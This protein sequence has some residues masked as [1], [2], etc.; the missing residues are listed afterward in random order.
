MKSII[1]IFV[2]IFNVSCFAQE[3]GTI[4]QIKNSEI[5]KIFN[6][7]E[8]LKEFK[9]ENLAIRIFIL[10]NESG[11]AGFN[12]GEITHNIYIAVSEFDELPNQ[13]LFCIKNLYAM[14]I[15]NIDYSNDN[16]AFMEISY[17][18]NDKK[19]HEKYKITINEI[20]KAS[21]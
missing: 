2:F 4:E 21:R 8:L 9:T 3:T 5:V 18:K 12:N 1:I 15:E 10:G 13:S 6:Q 20:I 11:S 16:Y 14:E 19:K 17:I 7:V